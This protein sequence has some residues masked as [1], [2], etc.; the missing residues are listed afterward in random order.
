MDRIL[1]NKD[2]KM[3]LQDLM[4][5]IEIA[6]DFTLGDLCLII[7]Q[8][9]ELDL[10]DFSKI[11]QWPIA[12]FLIECLD[13]EKEACSDLHYLRLTWQYS[14]EKGETPWGSMR[15]EVDAI[16]EIWDDYQPGG[17]FYEEGKDYSN[18][19]HWG[20]SFSPLYEMKN[21]PIRIEP[22]M[23]LYRE[24]EYPM[25]EENYFP[26][27]DVTLLDLIYSLFWEFSFYGGPEQR[28]EISFDLQE[29]VRKIKEEHSE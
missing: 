21:L 12:G 1:L 22:K 28:D 13:L 14:Y 19:N 9:D 20:I 18:C 27:P 24:L 5:P 8:F 29:T 16:G 15:L 10:E 6:D 4:S 2:Y 23:L 3:R 11:I 7:T 17:Q 26:A 25:T